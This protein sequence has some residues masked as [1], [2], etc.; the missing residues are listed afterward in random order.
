MK[1]SQLVEKFN[2]EFQFPDGDFNAHK[3]E[4]PFLRWLQQSEEYFPWGQ[5]AGSKR[6]KGTGR[7]VCPVEI[8]FNHSLSFRLRSIKETATSISLIGTRLIS[9]NDIKTR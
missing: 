2:R 6:C 7:I 5:R 8:N 4:L 9:K 3:H 1:F